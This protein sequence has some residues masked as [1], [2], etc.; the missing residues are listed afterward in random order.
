MYI[1]IYGLLISFL[2]AMFLTYLLIPFLNRLK[3]GQVVREDGPRSH[4]VKTG[5]PTMG[6]L[7]VLLTMTAV[8]IGFSFKYSG[9]WPVLAAVTGCGIIGFADDY[10][11][12]VLKRSLGLRA[13]YKILGL[14]AVSILFVLYLLR[15]VGTGMIIPFAERFVDLGVWL[16]IPLAVVVI[17][18]STNSLNLTDGLDG[19]A[20]GV[21]VIIMTFFTITAIALEQIEMVV[22]CSVT[23][24]AALGF[25]VFN[26]CPA[27]VFMG[28]TGSLLLGGAIGIAALMLR[29]PLILLIVAGV[30]VLESLSVLI[31]VTYFKL[32]GKRIFRMAPLHHHFELSGWR[33]TSV[34]WLFW[35]ATVLLCVLGLFSLR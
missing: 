24:G 15:S 6:G 12:V 35:A 34:V 21:T 1:Q 32:T 25:L 3:V 22:F 27:R 4:L 18:S 16:Y 33:E 13:S 23:A 10:I 7:A 2:A 20:A 17:L 26:I 28:D 31:Q 5:T 29:M 14:S 19:L 8:L 11:K 30:C 9:I